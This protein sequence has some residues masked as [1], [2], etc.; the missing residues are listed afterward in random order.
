MT[1]VE[2][3]TCS[4]PQ[5]MLEFLRDSASDRKLR[6]FA[7]ACCRRVWALITDESFRTAI[8]AAELYA[9]SKVTKEQ[10]NEARNAAIPAFVQLHNG[11]DE[12]PAAALSAAG[13]PAPKK[14]F[15]E[16]FLDAFDDPWWKDEFDKG[17]RHAPA[18]V[19]AKHAAWAAAHTQGQRPLSGSPGELAE[20]KVQA[21]LLL[22]VFGNPFRPIT[23]NGAWLTWRGG[24]IPLLAQAI[25]D[26]HA[27]DRMPLLADALEEAGCTDA[28]ILAHCRGPGPHVRGCWVVDLLLGK[29]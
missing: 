8:Q 4:D 26:D 14:S 15:F 2:W 17:D 13:I 5:P 29:G 9:D 3:L 24:T 16:Q 7:V 22:E 20:Q 18:V 1:E 21:S 6:L 28:D 27:F 10:M 11:E 19:T 25:Y 23:L 12:A